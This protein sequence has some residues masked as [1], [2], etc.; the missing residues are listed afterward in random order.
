MAAS[1]ARI[2]ASVAANTINYMS[3]E[4]GETIDGPEYIE[5]FL[6]IDDR[7]LHITHKKTQ[8][9][10]NELLHYDDNKFHGK[11]CCV[12]DQFI[13]HNCCNPIPVDWLLDKCVSESLT[14][15]RDDWSDF[16]VMEEDK[17]KIEAYYTQ[18]CFKLRGSPQEEQTLAKNLNKLMLSPRSYFIKKKMKKSKPLPKRLSGRY[19]KRVVEKHVKKTV[20]I[21]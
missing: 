4:D 18:N 5:L 13:T 6:Q 15:S 17:K 21:G 8:K 14:L 9:E 7:Q 11:V 1:A 19:K 16:D 12:C 3:L 20:C 2:V 10:R